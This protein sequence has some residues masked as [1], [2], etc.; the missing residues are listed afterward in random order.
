MHNVCKQMKREKS[1]MNQET[2]KGLKTIRLSKQELK[3]LMSIPGVEGILSPKETSKVEPKVTRRHVSA[4]K[5]ALSENGQAFI[6]MAVSS[7]KVSVVP[8]RFYD[9]KLNYAMNRSK[10]PIHGKSE[11]RHTFW[12]DLSPKQ[13]SAIGQKALRTRLANAKA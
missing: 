3:K 11:R 12:D 4:I 10:H 9:V 6:R 2:K 8:A 1:Q 5:K 13:R 7:G